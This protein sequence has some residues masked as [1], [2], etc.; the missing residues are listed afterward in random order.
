[1]SYCTAADLTERMSNDELIQL[2]DDS[3]SG[4]V[5]PDVILSAIAAA[6]DI[7]DGYLRGRYSVPLA[8]TPV[9]VK[10]LALD[11]TAYRLY[12]RRNQLSVND[13]IESLYKNAVSALK[14][15]AAGIIKLELPD[16]GA[17]IP[18]RG[19]YYTTPKRKLFGDAEL[20]KF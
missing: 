14:D 9:V 2:T 5:N 3:G 17:Q 6:Q 12:K 7:V 13:A 18:L 15:I 8:T 19:F 10:N 16:T 1:M 11:L 20:E 4:S